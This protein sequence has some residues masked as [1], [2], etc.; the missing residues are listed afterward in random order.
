MACSSLSQKQIY[1]SKSDFWKRAR[2]ATS[3]H[4]T[5]PSSMHLKWNL[6]SIPKHLPQYKYLMECS[7]L[8]AFVLLSSQRRV[9]M[10][11]SCAGTNW[12]P[13]SSLRAKPQ[14]RGRWRNASPILFATSSELRLSAARARFRLLRIVYSIKEVNNEVA[15]CYASNLP[16]QIG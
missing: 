7:N 16:L 14:P 3:P 1:P 12:L 6:F 2:L 8:S 4:M 11:L 9:C 10:A 5:Y 13:S 15:R